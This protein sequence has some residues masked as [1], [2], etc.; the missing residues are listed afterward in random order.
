MT[1]AFYTFFVV[2]QSLHTSFII[3]ENFE[4]KKKQNPLNQSSGLRVVIAKQGASTNPCPLHAY[5]R[6]LIC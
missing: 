5:S 3:M 2:E 6:M 1:Q 4:R